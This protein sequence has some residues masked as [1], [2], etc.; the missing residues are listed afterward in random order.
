LK[1]LDIHA[2]TVTLKAVS[3]LPNWGDK[4]VKLE[5]LNNTCYLNCNY[6]FILRFILFSERLRAA[7]SGGSSGVRNLIFF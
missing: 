1:L 6:K 2:K 7:G 4:F 3:I 5:R